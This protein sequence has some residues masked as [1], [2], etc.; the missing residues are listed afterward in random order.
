MDKFQCYSYSVVVRSVRCHIRKEMQCCE[1]LPPS[2]PPLHPCSKVTANETGWSES[3][4]TP[5][6]DFNLTLHICATVVTI[7]SGE[8]GKVASSKCDLTGKI[9]I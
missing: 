5:E 2:A 7:F 6:E 1:R 4:L 3:F 9:M 8:Y